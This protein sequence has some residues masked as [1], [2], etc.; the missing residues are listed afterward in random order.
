MTVIFAT[1]QSLQVIHDAQTMGLPDFDLTI[2]DEA[3]RTA[4]RDDSSFTKIHDDDF[5]HSRLRLYMTATPKIYSDSVQKQANKSEK[6][7]CSM[8]DENIFGPEFY[9]LSFSEAVKR[10]L[11]TDYKVMIFMI[12]SDSSSG[13]EVDDY[14]KILGTYK[15]LA[16]EISSEDYDFI[17]NDPQPMKR[18]VAFTSTIQGSKNFAV[19]FPKVISSDSAHDKLTCEVRHIDGTAPASERSRLLQWLKDDSD[20]CRILS[21]ARCLSEGVDVPALDAVIF[22]NARK[23]EIDIVQSVGRVMRKAPGKNFGYV[24]LPV[25]VT[26]GVEPEQALDDN[27]SYKTVWQVLQALRAHDDHFNAVINSLDL[28]DSSPKIRVFPPDSERGADYFT[29]EKLKQWRDAVNIRIVKKCGDREYWDKWIKDL[30]NVAENNSTRLNEL[31]NSDIQEINEAFESFMNGLHENI[32]PSITQAEALDM[33]SQHMISRPVFDELFHEFSQ[34]NPVS[35]VMQNMLNTLAKYNLESRASELEGFYQDVHEKVM[36]ISDDR[37]RQ[38]VIRRIYERFFRQAFKETAQRLGIVYTPSE[39]VDF[40]IKSA[41]WAVIHELG[42]NEGLGARGVHILDP[43]SGTGTFMVRLIQ[44][45]LMTPDRLRDKYYVWNQ[46]EKL[47]EPSELHANELLLLAYYISAINI[48]AA[49]YEINGSYTP[50]PGIILTD[51]FRLNES[52]TLHLHPVFQ[53]NGRR[54]YEQEKSDIHVI[55]GNPPYS[56]GKKGQYKALDE[57]ITDSYALDS[58]A[59]NKNSLYDSYIRA[60][61]W[62]SERIRDKG[63]ICFVSNGAF[64]DSNSGDGLR[65]SL[66]KEFRKIYIFNLRGNANTQGELRQKECGNVFGE[67]TRLPI[68][69]TLFV[70]DNGSTD[71]H[72]I[73]YYEVGDYMTREDKLRELSRLESFG[74]MS[75]R[76][77]LREITPNKYGDWVNKRSELFESFMRLGNKKESGEFAI[78]DDRYSAGSKSGHD[79]YSYNFSRDEVCKNITALKS[80]A[81]LN[82][83]TLRESLYS[84]FC[85]MITHFS[86]ETVQRVYQ[87]PAMFPHP[88]TKNLTICIPGIGSN[89]VFSALMVDTLP[90][91]TIQSAAQCFPLYWYED[92]GSGLFHSGIE[93]R[94]GISN[95]ALRLF[96]RHYNDDS[97]TKEDIFYYIYGVLS[98]PDYAKKFSNDVKRM[99]ARV[100]F[101]RE[102]RLFEEAGRKL[103]DLHVNYERV[104]KWPV[105]LV[106]SSESRDYVIKKMK[107]LNKSAIRYNDSLVIENIPESAWRYIVNG[108]SA[109]DWIIERY[110]DSTDKGSNIRN[111]CNN[112]GREHGDSSYVIDLIARVTRVSVESVKIFESMPELGI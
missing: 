96:R 94:D 23:S 60:I 81:T 58:R 43:F 107:A 64:I 8:E 78:F 101:V 3:H 79:V 36:V 59:T 95:Y 38:E 11:L 17:H 69:I 70:K 19:N 51:T 16:K 112:W 76:G 24:I 55:I 46:E 56:V 42:I 15:A 98:S 86:R 37:G 67:G 41:D 45:G 66:A 49:F 9:R 105:S 25:A 109:L 5:I 89:K 57:K 4:G 77:L 93:R 13:S 48:E 61:K 97:I 63:V 91:L 110:Q 32:N 14:A 104:D 10:E 2:C 73:Y 80:S 27:E 44:L 7:L 35:Q 52:P 71:S 50:F 54:A 40:I 92:T 29:P 74:T 90:S 108:R 1:Y 88:D 53:E 20:S 72:R 21:N 102:F 82:D 12:D 83:D 33:L 106:W 34:R 85:K 47:H 28:N 87:M 75:G 99:L 30:S 39:V 31:I 22:L 100:P 6:P 103:A 62:A 111:D 18:A 65:K 84:P 68:A 26:P